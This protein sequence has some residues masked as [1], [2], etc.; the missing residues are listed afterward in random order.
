MHPSL[1]KL[2]TLTFKGEL[3]PD[4]SRRSDGPGRVSDPL[5]DRDL[6]DDDRAVAV[7]RNLAKQS[8]RTVFS[9]GWPSLTCRFCFWA[10]RL[11]FVFTS[12]GEKAL[13]FTPSE[14]DFLFPAPFH[15]RELLIFKLAKIAGRPRLHGADSRH[16]V[17]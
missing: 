11:M 13:Y 4:V 17:S 14:V 10:R 6:R 9:A 8:G 16:F 5:H 7:R 2:M 12:A 15:R 1:Y 3:A